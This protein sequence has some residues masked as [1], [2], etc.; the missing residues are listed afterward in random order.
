MMF[1]TSRGAFLLSLLFCL[2]ALTQAEVSTRQ[3]ATSLD[4]E[5]TVYVSGPEDADAAIVLVHDWFGVSPFFEEAV[6]RLGSLG[7]RVIGVDLYDGH[8]ATTHKEAGALMAAVDPERAGIKI[9]AAIAAA[10]RPGRR[11]AMMGFSMGGMFAMRASIRNNDEVKATVIF[12]GGTVDDPQLL[13]DI[14]GPVLAVYGSRDGNAADAA[15]TFSKAADEAGAA[16]EIYIY[17]GAVHAFAQPLFNQGKTYDPVATSV[18]W[19]LAE[20]FFE[21]QLSGE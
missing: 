7:Y 3:L 18:A 12:Y 9:D 5:V 21:R 6:A 20:N 8:S 13:R 17:P 16:A 2:P 10:R 1:Q 14:G 4:D 11:F 15:A 19:M